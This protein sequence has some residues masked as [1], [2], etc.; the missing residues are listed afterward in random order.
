[1]RWTPEEA[2]ERF[3]TGRVARLA[4]VDSERQPHVVPV[5]FAVV[6]DTIVT[7]VDH[8]PKRTR[9]LRRVANIERNPRVS[10]LVDHYSDNWEQ[11][12]W[13]RA[14]GAARVATDE[15]TRDETRT[16][17]CARYRQYRKHPTEGPVIVVTV[18]RWSGWSYQG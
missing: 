18:R 17:L 11:L 8:K 4:T 12:W 5:T 15:A 13:A 16:L 2:R 7:A 10:L 9:D 1:M 3:A 14:D 6:A